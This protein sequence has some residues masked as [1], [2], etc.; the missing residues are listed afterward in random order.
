MRERWREGGGKREG[1]RDKDTEEFEQQN[2]NN[3]YSI[4][5]IS[6]RPDLTVHV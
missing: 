1:E 4:K 5:Q 2:G 3:M 6:V